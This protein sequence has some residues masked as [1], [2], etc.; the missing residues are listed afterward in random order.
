MTKRFS[1]VVSAVLLLVSCAWGAPVSRIT[2][3]GIFSDWQYVPV[4]TDP[5]DD[6]HDT[7]QGLPEDVPAYVDHVDVDLVE[8]KVTHDE[9]NVYAYFKSTGIIGRT[10]SH[11]VGTAG[12]YYVIVTI[13]VDNNDTT[14]YWL[15]EGGYFPTSSGYDM[16]M[17][18][19]FYDA[20]FNT[21]HY[22]NHGCLNVAE[23][24]QAKL[25]QANGI[26][27]VKP[28]TYDWYTQW[29]WWDTPQGDPNEILLPDGHSTIV[30]VADKGPVYQGIIEIVVSADGHEAEMKAPFRGFMKYP[31]SS[32]IMA[33]GKT[34][35]FSFSLEASGELAVGAQWASDT[36]LPITGY[37]LAPPT[38][39][40]DG[41]GLPDGWEADHELNP[42]DDGTTDVDQGAS[43][44]PDNDGATNLEEYNAGTDP[45]NAS[46]FPPPVKTISVPTFS[47]AIGK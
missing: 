34:M 28:G 22:L 16:N 37:Y 18:V 10:Q 32:P 7:D 41:D 6:Q 43:G 33:L 15:N 29:V 3:D 21:G 24:D 12:R 8:F 30:W 20:A 42:S 14:G 36:A 23:Y 47:V 38:E 19:E 9:N 2:L 17:E 39:D 25:D 1:A 5:V 4:Y 13:D 27:D 35:D 45:S 44:D 11:T 46:S 40:S 31:N 26:V